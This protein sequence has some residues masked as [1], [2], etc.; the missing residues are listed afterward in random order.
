[1][2]NPDRK[3][4]KGSRQVPTS[5]S[6]KSQTQDRSPK[7]LREL[8]S[9]NSEA[10]RHLMSLPRPQLRALLVNGSGDQRLVEH[11]LEMLIRNDLS[12]LSK[13]ALVRLMR[14]PSSPFPLA[15]VRDE[16]IRRKKPKQKAK[17]ASKADR[18]KKNAPKKGQA[19]R[20]GTLKQRAYSKMNVAP[21]LPSSDGDTWREHGA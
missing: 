13:K 4:K 8:L 1:M 7:V 10:I 2:L 6:E 19:M 3:A 21:M 15:M 14:Q 5:P 20:T 16:L 11:A 18:A 17:K 9:A 12:N